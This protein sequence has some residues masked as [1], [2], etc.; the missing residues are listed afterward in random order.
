MATQPVES[1]ELAG[2]RGAPLPC[3]LHG[4]APR[5]ALVLPGGARAGNRLG[6][7][8][9]R[10]D[11]HFTRT[12]LSEQGLSVLE[13][14]WDTDAIVGDDVE[15]W[16]LANAR[17]GYDAIAARDREP[18]LLVGRSLG[19]LAL[20]LLGDHDGAARLPSIWI[21][22]LMHRERVRESLLHDSGRA[23]RRF[24][25]CGGADPAYD[26]GVAAHLQEHG[27]DL[28]VVDRAGHGLDCGD[29]P[30]SARAL[31]EA[32]ERMRDFLAGALAII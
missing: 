29:A 19:T 2:D 3:V 31:A 17:A 24:V 5:C 22:P 12:L 1:F 10:P 7:S 16:L 27:D 4:N 15:A 25:L 14:W 21:A 13:V 30:A 8:P 20:A 18:A 28:V 23:T 9:A 26:P 32:L 6:G 11:L